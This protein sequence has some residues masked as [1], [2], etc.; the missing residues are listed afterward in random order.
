M[1]IERSICADVAKWAL[2][3][4]ILLMGCERRVETKGAS[5]V[6]AF[7]AIVDVNLPLNSVRWEVFGTPE[8]VGGVPGP[9]DFVTL[10]AEVTPAQPILIE[11]SKTGEIWIAPEAARPWLRQ[12]FRGIFAKY[13]NKYIDISTIAACKP[14]QAKLRKTGK[15]V[16]GFICNDVDA[17]VLYLTIFNSTS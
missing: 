13:A 6:T 4:A 5:D 17:S 14:I 9:T 10:I 1:D 7:Q 8:Y 16:P 12:K 2:C 11:E 15:L 3:T